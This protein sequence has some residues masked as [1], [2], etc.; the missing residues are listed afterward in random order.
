M[1]GEDTAVGAVFE[2]EE[3]FRGRARFQETCQLGVV[4]QNDRVRAVFG[5]DEEVGLRDV[6]EQRGAV[7]FAADVREVGAVVAAFAVR[8]MAADALPAGLGEENGTTAFGIAAQGEHFGRG[9]VRA[10]RAA[11]LLGREEALEEVADER[12]RR[13]VQRL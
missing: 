8:T 1:R 2:A 12:I 7:I 13:R 9:E 3:K 10:E 5:R 11:A 4:A 6:R